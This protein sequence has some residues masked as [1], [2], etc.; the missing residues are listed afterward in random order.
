M[1]ARMSE[2]SLPPFPPRSQVR[3]CPSNGPRQ[4]CCFIT[5]FCGRPSYRVTDG[6]PGFLCGPLAIILQDCAVMLSVRWGPGY[7]PTGANN[8]MRHYGRQVK[9]PNLE[10]GDD[11]QGRGNPAIAHEQL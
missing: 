5:S 10:R 6:W 4:V 8:S 3:Y 2:T 7:I 9:T 1:R 11:S